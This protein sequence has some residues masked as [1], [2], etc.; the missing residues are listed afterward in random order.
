[1][2]NEKFQTALKTGENFSS[3]VSGAWG[4]DRMAYLLEY[5]TDMV[6]CLFHDVSLL[7]YCEYGNIIYHI[8]LSKLVLLETDR[9]IFTFRY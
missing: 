3:L 8:S 5:R 6:H 9:K 1:M 7:H 2:Y 4:T